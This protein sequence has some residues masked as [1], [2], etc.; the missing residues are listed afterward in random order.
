MVKHAYLATPASMAKI[1]K[2]DSTNSWQRLEQK[3][4]TFITGGNAKLYSHFWR[5][6]DNK[7]KLTPFFLLLIFFITA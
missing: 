2:T 4:L 7:K 5:K 3:G 1:Q 6:F